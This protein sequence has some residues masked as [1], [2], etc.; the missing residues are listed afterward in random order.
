VELEHKK[1]LVKE[2]FFDCPMGM[3]L[4]NCLTKNFRKLSLERRMKIVDEIK[5]EEI[6]FLLNKHREC[7]LNRE[8]RRKNNCNEMY[9]L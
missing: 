5:E 3:A 2:L 6:E 1:I 9:Q 7:R 4:N 8:E